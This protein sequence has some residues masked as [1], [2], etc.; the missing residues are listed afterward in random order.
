M[1][2]GNSVGESR[3]EIAAAA[4]NSIDIEA[5]TCATLVGFGPDRAYLEVL[6]SELH[7]EL[8]FEK[9]TSKDM[10]P[11][12]TWDAGEGASTTRLIEGTIALFYKKALINTLETTMHD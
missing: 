2:G 7:G 8:C 4:R 11:V 5:S 12:L 10:I 1:D 6:R 3:G 9:L